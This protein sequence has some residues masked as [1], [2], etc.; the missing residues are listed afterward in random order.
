[1]GTLSHLKVFFFSPPDWEKQCVIMFRRGQVGRVFLEWFLEI[2][3]CGNT[4]LVKYQLMACESCILIM[5]MCLFFLP[6]VEKPY[7]TVM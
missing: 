2:H 7:V 4:A 5:L 3:L 1:M 6:G